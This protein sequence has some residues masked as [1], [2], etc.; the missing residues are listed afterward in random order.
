MK[1]WLHRDLSLPHLHMTRAATANVH[2]RGAGG[3][4]LS[5]KSIPPGIRSW[6]ARTMVLSGQRMHMGPLRRGTPLP[7]D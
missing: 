4:P 2:S 7:A 6:R 1:G 5:V 3:S